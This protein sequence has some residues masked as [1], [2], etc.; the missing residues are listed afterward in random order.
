[1]NAS[2]ITNF[3]VLPPRQQYMSVI[4]L[5]DLLWID[6]P[7]SHRTAHTHIMPHIE[8]SQYLLIYS[9]IIALSIWFKNIFIYYIR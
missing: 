3:Y 7:R 4:D 6:E 8:A 1:M 2:A 5:L 9:I